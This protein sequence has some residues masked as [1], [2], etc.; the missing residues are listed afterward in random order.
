MKDANT[1]NHDH[2]EWFSSLYAENYAWLSRW[3]YRHLTSTLHLEDIL[4]DTFLKLF[5]SQQSHQLREPKAYLASTARCIAIDKARREIVEKKYLE[6]LQDNPN[7]AVQESPEQTLIV[8]ELL[9]RITLAI[10]D[11]PDRPR[12][13]LLLYYIE[14]LKQADIAKQLNLTTRTVQHDLAKAM[15]HCHQWIQQNT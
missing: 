15:V 12:L 4:Q 3:L 8:I 5:I 13:C 11:L 14:G 6:F 9:Q 7:I 1:L 2:N 10:R